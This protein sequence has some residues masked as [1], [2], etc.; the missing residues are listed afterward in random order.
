L[1]LNKNRLSNLGS[2]FTDYK[3][4]GFPNEAALTQA[5]QSPQV[6]RPEVSPA[7]EQNGGAAS[8]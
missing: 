8:A 7:A 4:L 6:P 5:C 3:K 2:N 1:S